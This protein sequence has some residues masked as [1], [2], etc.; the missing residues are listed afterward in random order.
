[1]FV[2]FHYASKTMT[3]GPY[4]DA[5][6]RM[7]LAVEGNRV[8]DLKEL[9]TE[10][11][12]PDIRGPGTETA[13]MVASRRGHDE[14]LK[15]LLDSGAKVNARTS[16]TRK[17][18]LMFAAEAGFPSTCEILLGRGANADSADEAGRT[19]LNYAVRTR[20]TLAVAVLLKGG[21]NPNGHPLAHETPL[22]E[23]ATHGNLPCVRVLLQAGA[24]PNL[25][26]RSGGFPLLNT[27]APE[28]VRELL[29][30]GADINMRDSTGTNP[31]MHFALV[32][33][34][35]LIRCYIAAG[36]DVNATDEDGRTALMR[37]ASEPRRDVAQLLVEAGA[38]VNAL[39]EPG[40]SVLDYIESD[41]SGLASVRVRRNELVKFL[42]ARGAKT[43]AELGS[44]PVAPTGHE[45][46]FLEIRPRADPAAFASLILSVTDWCL[47]PPEPI[48]A[49][50]L[51]GVAFPVAEPL[52]DGIIEARLDACREKGAYLFRCALR[53]RLGLLP[54]ND[55]FE[56]IAAMGTSAPNYGRESGQI[57]QW[58]QDLN[59]DQ[60][61]LLMGAG[62]D[63]VVGKFIRAIA[64]CRALARR[65]C[66][67]CPDA[68]QQGSGT[69][70]ALARSLKETG[71]FCLWWD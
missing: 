33:G 13:L 19:A 42:R 66:N 50:G 27:H 51:L 48:E 6:L 61:F 10:G 1:V 12:G 67:F 3:M 56:I 15:L 45:T 14:A 46:R 34:F 30:A 36:I 9:I 25:K 17:T 8:S 28:V 53:G 59:S 20:N 69:V 29:Q 65:I 55:P 40:Q 11:V 2:C 70:A 54:T 16:K 7:F 4:S 47:H 52:V 22:M 49:N 38:N 44:H 57:I 21:A 43:A 63:F 18:P 60:P 62:D 24:D 37:L 39:R 23:A 26:S 41:H 71:R 5:N 68:V 58:L 64:N 35:E 31:M 32:G